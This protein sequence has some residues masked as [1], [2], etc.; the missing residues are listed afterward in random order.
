MLCDNL[1]DF[2]S[3][4]ES[5]INNIFC[6][7][8]LML[9]IKAHK[10]DAYGLLLFQKKLNN[11]EFYMSPRLYLT[12][13]FYCIN[14]FKISFKISTSFSLLRTIFISVSYSKA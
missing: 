11:K 2:S 7:I 10:H 8:K 6:T 3:I 5:I 1:L 9:N 13:N 14:S 12:L 4:L